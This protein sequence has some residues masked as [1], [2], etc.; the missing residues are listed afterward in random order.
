MFCPLG[1]K[2]LRKTLV[3]GGD[4]IV[5]EFSPQVLRHAFDIRN[6]HWELLDLPLCCLILSFFP[7]LLALVLPKPPNQWFWPALSGFVNHPLCS[8]AWRGLSIFLDLRCNVR[9]IRSAQCI[10]DLKTFFCSGGWLLSKLKHQST[11]DSLRR[12]LVMIEPYLPVR[13]LSLPLQ[14]ST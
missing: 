3:V 13:Q 4:P 2:N 14:K 5:L 1:K 8:L 7:T 12:T 9:T 10:R 11:W 6:Y